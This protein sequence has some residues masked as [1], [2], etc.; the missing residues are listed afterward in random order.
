MRIRVLA[1]AASLAVAGAGHAAAQSAEEGLKLFF[2]TGSAAVGRD[3]GD[4]LDRA[5]RLFRD[6]NPIVMIVSGVADTVGSPDRN[7][8][9]SLRR[10]H[11][12]A[13]GQ[14]ARA[15]P[16]QRLQVVGLGNSELV[17]RTADEAP[18]QDNRVVIITWR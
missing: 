13:N 2:Q 16:A 10:A 12:V 7:L 11:T 18:N 3:G 6:G 1:L 5:A 4:T 15:I 8:D 17:V 9:L 14:E